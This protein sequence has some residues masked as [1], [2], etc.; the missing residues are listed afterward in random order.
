MP[1]VKKITAF[2]T[3]RIR[4]EVLRKGKP[5]ETCFFDGDNLPTTTHFGLFENENLIGVVSVYKSNSTLFLEK[6]QFQI[7]GMAVLENFQSKGFGAQLLKTAE[8]FCFEENANLIWF[9]AREKAVSFYTKSGYS[10]LGDSFTIP[11]VGIHFVMFK[12]N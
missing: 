11:N 4:Q 2:E 5:I 7:R 3:I 9:N 8:N 10:V 12:K 1:V 6:I